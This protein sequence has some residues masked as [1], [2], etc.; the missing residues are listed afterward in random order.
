MSQKSL[1]SEKKIS[2]IG[3]D[4]IKNSFSTDFK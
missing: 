2:Y 1:D 3:N 4:N